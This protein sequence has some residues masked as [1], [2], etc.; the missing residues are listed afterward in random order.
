MLEKRGISIAFGGMPQTRIPRAAATMFVIP[1]DGVIISHS[2]PL[3]AALVDAE[4]HLD[5]LPRVLSK[6]V[7]LIPAEPLGV[8]KRC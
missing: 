5:I 2:P 7:P 8:Q 3:I 6:I 4:Q 1:G